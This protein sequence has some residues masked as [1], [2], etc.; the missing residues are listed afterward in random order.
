[1]GT[2]ISCPCVNCLCIPVC[3]F[4]LYSKLLTCDLIW[5]YIVDADQDIFCVKGHL[6]Q[7]YFI[8]EAIKPTTWRVNLNG[9]FVY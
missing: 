1:M 6:K 3:K 9:K 5:R 8:H 2:T 4:K 7:R